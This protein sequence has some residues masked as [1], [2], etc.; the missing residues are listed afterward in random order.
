MKSILRVKHAMNFKVWDGYSLS[1]TLYPSFTLSLLNKEGNTYTKRIGLCNGLKLV[2][3]VNSVKVLNTQCSLEYIRELC[4]I[5]EDPLNIVDEVDQKFNDLYY[6]LLT[7]WRGV[8]LSTASNDF[9]HVFVSIFLSKRTS[10][11]R[12]VL[13]WMSSLFKMVESIDE[14]SE[15][16]VKNLI[17]SPQ[18]IELNRVIKCY[19]DKVRYN[20]IRGNVDAVRLNLLE[21]KGVG[22]KVTYA[23]LLHAMRRTDF[24]PVDTHLMYFTT[25]VLALRGLEPD[26][27]VCLRYRCDCCKH[28]CILGNLRSFFG[29]ALG[30]LQTVCYVHV[31]EFCKKVRCGECVL[32]G[33]NLCKLQQF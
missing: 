33:R 2:D 31:K 30:Y 14:L 25:K 18:A 5:T 8:G 26:K 21:I 11:H 23:F 29:R 17:R 1:Q 27:S 4:G 24:A 32:K 16:D 6:Y 13:S 9:D 3:S 15:I 22:P 7:R 10:Y 20:V 12:N 28:Q 19:I